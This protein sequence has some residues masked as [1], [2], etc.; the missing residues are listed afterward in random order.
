[1]P[2]LLLFFGQLSGFI[3]VNRLVVLLMAAVLVVLDAGLVYLAVRAF[4]RE[5]ILTRWR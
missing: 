5:A 1:V 3:I 4:Q 2:L